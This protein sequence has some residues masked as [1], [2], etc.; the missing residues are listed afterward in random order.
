MGT[1]LAVMTTGFSVLIATKTCCTAGQ[2]WTAA[3]TVFFRASALNP[4]NTTL[5]AAP[6]RAQANMDATARGE[7]GM[8]QSCTVW[9]GSIQ[10]SLCRATAAQKLSLLET[11]NSCRVVRSDTPANAA[12]SGM[13]AVVLHLLRPKP[14]KQDLR[15]RRLKEVMTDFEAHPQGSHMLEVITSQCDICVIT[16]SFCSDSPSNHGAYE[17]VTP[18]LADLRMDSG[19]GME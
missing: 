12:A 16:G 11:E 15:I 7:G 2:L 19:R 8:S 1:S 18:S 17:S 14:C 4:A 10:L 13:N 3:S 9:K 5:W 6:I